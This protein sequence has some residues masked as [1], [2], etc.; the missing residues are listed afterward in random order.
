MD[1]DPRDSDSRDEHRFGLTRDR[2]DQRP[3]LGRGGNSRE[4]HDDDG[5]R[6]DAR[7]PNRERDERPL[8]NDARDVFTR[9]L[10][11]PRGA[12]RQLVRDRD[13]EYPLRGSESRTLPE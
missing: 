9:Q 2:N 8:D 6:E 1:F 12:D 5:R 3:T 13:R 7:A 11:L 10:N 4:S